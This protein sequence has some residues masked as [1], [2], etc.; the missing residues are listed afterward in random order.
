MILFIENKFKDLPTQYKEKKSCD[1]HT[2]CSDF[3]DEINRFVGYSS[4]SRL[5]NLKNNLFDER[6]FNL[7]NEYRKTLRFFIKNFEFNYYCSWVQ[8]NDYNIIIKSDENGKKL[9]CYSRKYNFNLITSNDPLT[10]DEKTYILRF[11][12]EVYDNKFKKLNDIPLSLQTTS[13]MSLLT[14]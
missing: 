9:M 12:N 4:N 1:F 5:Q 14:N 7:T 8:S 13:L 10:E 11:A 3:L 2:Y 6:T